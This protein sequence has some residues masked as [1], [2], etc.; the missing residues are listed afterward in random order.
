[1]KSVLGHI[2][3][4][5]IEPYLAPQIKRGSLQAVK[6]YVSSIKILREIAL[7]SFR[8]GIVAGVLVTG[9]VLIV[10]GTL[11]LLP[12][13]QEA[14][15]ISVIGIG[16]VMTS[17][18]SY[19]AFEG[20]KERNWIKWSKANQLISAAIGDWDNPLIPPDPRV[21]MSKQTADRAAESERSAQIPMRPPIF[22]AA[23]ELPR[24]V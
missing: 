5:V 24:P 12:I 21:V 2:F 13:T 7:T 14:M 4:N 3:E 10:I 18:A 1:M 19:I 11:G 8:L 16:F 9:L 15:L 6:G 23:A 22:E 20:A 17:V